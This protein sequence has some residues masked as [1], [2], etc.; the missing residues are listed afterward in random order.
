MGTP[1]VGTACPLCGRVQ[2]F[3][4]IRVPKLNADDLR[5]LIHELGMTLVRLD[6]ALGLNRPA[7]SQ[8]AVSA[9]EGNEID[10]SETGLRSI[11]I[12]LLSHLT[13]KAGQLA[14]IKATV[15]PV[16]S[17]PQ[18]RSRQN[19]GRCITYCIKYVNTAFVN[20]MEYVTSVC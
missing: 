7:D 3:R 14:E 11:V 16:R 4:L 2:E 17:A 8:E 12:A 10:G 9:I 1:R 6:R 13:E 19:K 18:D 5:K 20:Q 15:D